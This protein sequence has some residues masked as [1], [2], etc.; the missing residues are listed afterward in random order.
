[1]IECRIAKN[2]AI[3]KAVDLCFIKGF[4]S[5]HRATS[6]GCKNRWFGGKK[7]KLKFYCY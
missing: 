5:Y 7:V 4:R 1:M 2:D 3:T 6:E